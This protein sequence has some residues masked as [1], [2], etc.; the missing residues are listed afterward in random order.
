[1]SDE[2]AVADLYRLAFMPGQFRCP[3]CGFHWSIQTINVARGEIGTTEQ[4]RQAPD[5]LNDGTR[6][7]HVTYREQLEAYAERLKEEFDKFEA[8]TKAVSEFL[9]EMYAT[10]IDPVEQPKL[11][12]AEM[13]A[14]LLK[15]A[16][17]Q[18]EAIHG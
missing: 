15:T 17:D 14:L 13:C 1:M 3:Q 4:D 7:V 10:M 11:A 18:R 2:T 12:V 8:H 5:C 6:M 9:N 16:R